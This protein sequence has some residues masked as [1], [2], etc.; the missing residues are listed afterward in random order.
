MSPLSNNI[1][2]QN[3]IATAVDIA[4]RCSVWNNINS[5]THPSIYDLVWREIKLRLYINV[6]DVALKQAADVALKQAAEFI[7][8]NRHA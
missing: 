5:T 4:V 3:K 2:F 1:F 8:N 7:Y 6:P